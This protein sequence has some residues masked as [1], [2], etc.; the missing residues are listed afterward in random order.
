MTGKK[1]LPLSASGGRGRTPGSLQAVQC[2]GCVGVREQP[3][4]AAWN[5]STRFGSK[6]GVALDFIF[7]RAA[8][9]QDPGSSSVFFLTR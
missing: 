8:G 9:R 3:P 2:V 4:P 6:K 7:G 1:K 5:S